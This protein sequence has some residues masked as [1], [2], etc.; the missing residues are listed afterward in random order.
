MTREDT[1]HNE[2]S[3]KLKSVSDWQN[4]INEYLDP[5]KPWNI[6][7][8]LFIGGYFLAFLSIWDWY[9]GEWPLPVLVGLAFLALHLEG[10]VIHDACHTAAHPNKWINQFMNMRLMV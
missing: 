2:T 9:R 7:V 1:L 4:V 8:G 3:K 10:T 5:P 6:T